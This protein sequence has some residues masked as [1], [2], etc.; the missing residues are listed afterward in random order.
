MDARS[1]IRKASFWVSNLF[2]IAATVLGVFLAATQG[3]EQAVQF[4]NLR[5]DKNN[6]YMRQ[7]L[8]GEL[9]DNAG[10]VKEYIAKVSN[11]VV[12]PQLV[13]EDFVW[14]NMT[15]AANALET[16]TELLREAQRFHRRVT[17]IMATPHFNDRMKAQHLGELVKH[18]EENVLPAFDADIEALA[19]SLKARNVDL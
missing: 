5:G 4:D 8:R 16:P 11:Q 13:L 12:S 15:Y 9:A 14:N 18:L 3:F 17:E 1:D 6:Y 19:K 7:S 10:Y 2:I